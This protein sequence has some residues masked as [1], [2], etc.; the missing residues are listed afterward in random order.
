MIYKDKFQCDNFNR[1]NDDVDIQLNTL[2][3]KYQ[4]QELFSTRTNQ[5]KHVLLYEKLNGQYDID[6]L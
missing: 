4:N 2:Y 5:K 1:I 3:Q 6:M